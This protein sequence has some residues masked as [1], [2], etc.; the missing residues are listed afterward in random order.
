MGTAVGM[1][2][3]GAIVPMHLGLSC[4]L[5]ATGQ[6]ALDRAVA[7][8]GFTWWAPGSIPMT[9]RTATGI[10]GNT[11]DLTSLRFDGEFQFQ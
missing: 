1:A 2:T 11:K 8:Q 10:A 3:V 6:Q 7:I 9:I 4:A 5:R